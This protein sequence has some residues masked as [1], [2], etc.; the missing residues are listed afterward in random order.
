MNKNKRIQRK[1][2]KHQSSWAQ[3]EEERNE[4]ALRS[5]FAQQRIKAKREAEDKVRIE[6]E[7]QC[8]QWGMGDVI[9]PVEIQRASVYSNPKRVVVKSPSIIDVTEFRPTTANRKRKPCV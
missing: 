6:R 9:A 3:I 5:Y 8:K 2:V 4:A 7:K 1:M